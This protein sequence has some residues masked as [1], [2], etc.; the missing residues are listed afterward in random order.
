MTE[1]N[2]SPSQSE[3]EEAPSEDVRERARRLQEKVGK[4]SETLGRVEETLAEAAN[5]RES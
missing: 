3:F 1:E 2:S 5:D 4:L